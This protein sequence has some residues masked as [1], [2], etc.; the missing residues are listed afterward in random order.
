MSNNPIP[1]NMKAILALAE[2]CHDG[3][4]DHQDAVGLKLTRAA[5]LAALIEA[6][7]GSAPTSP[8]PPGAPPP[9]PPLPPEPGLI[10]LF[11]EARLATA[12]A[13][14]AMQA[15]DAEV[16]QFL[17][18]ARAVLSGP[19]GKKWSAEWVLAGFTEP[20]S[21]AVPDTR[22]ERFA[23][24]NTLAIYLAQHPQHEVPG[25]GPVAELTA[26]KAQSLHMQLSDART[27][28]ND[29]ANDQKAAKA[30]RDAGVEAL[31]RQLIAFVDELT[32]RLGPDDPRWELF[33]LNIPS[34]PR[35][36]EPASALVLTPA[37]TGRVAADWKRGTRSSNH[38]VM[39]QIVGTDADYREYAKSGEITEKLITG[40]PSGAT[41]KVKIIALNGSLEAADGPEGEIGVP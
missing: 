6:L 13:E 34:S 37:G 3:C 32:L 38:R 29:A 14:T 22:D 18:N 30:A 33:G 39:I 35:A 28:V 7:K 11:D 26:S 27:A 41:L 9:P 40:L 24:I 12:T 20:G 5:D 15:K 31:R 2:D 21:T 36:P 19:L 1:T 16:R 23:S 25:G 10:Y 4:V 8:L 17:T